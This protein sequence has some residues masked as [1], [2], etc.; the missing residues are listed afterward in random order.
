MIISLLPEPSAPTEA[1]GDAGWVKKRLLEPNRRRLKR[2][3]PPS[4]LGRQVPFQALLGDRDN[5]LIA[6]P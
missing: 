3:R 5:Q 2:S 1:A 4:D 6:A